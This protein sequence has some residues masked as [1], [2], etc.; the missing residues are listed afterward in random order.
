MSGHWDICLPRKKQNRFA[1]EKNLPKEFFFFYNYDLLSTK[2]TKPFT[3]DSANFLYRPHGKYSVCYFR[4]LFFSSPCNLLSA[5][6]CLSI[7]RKWLNKRT[8][9]RRQKWSQLKSPR[10]TRSAAAG[11]IKT[12]STTRV[13]PNQPRPGIIKRLKTLHKERVS[14][15]AY[16]SARGQCGFIETSSSSLSRE[17]DRR[18]PTHDNDLFHQHSSTSLSICPIDRRSG[19]EEGETREIDAKSTRAR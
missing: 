10:D 1:T 19:R 14:I 9:W 6:T 11:R 18:N 13:Q 15:R 4:T 12:Y 5:H 3:V 16:V 17:G 2:P 8:A 7:S